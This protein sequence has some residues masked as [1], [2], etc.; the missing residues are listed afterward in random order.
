MRQGDEGQR[1]IGVAFDVGPLA[2][3]RTGIGAAV[4]ALRDHL[5]HE[6]S[7]RLLP[8]L[9]S[10]RATPD[11]GVRR[12]P[13]PAMVAHR[14]WARTDRPRADRWLGRADVVHGTNYV[15][16]PSAAP[17]IVSVYDCWFLAHGREAHPDVVRA[18]RVLLRSLEHGAV[19]HASSH[20][21][22]AALL[23]HSPRADVRVVHLGAMPLP[24]PTA[25]CP[26]AELDGRPYV[27]AVATL[28]RRKNLPRLV[29]AFGEVASAVPDVRLVIAGGDGD[30]RRDVDAAIDRLPPSVGGRVLL[31]GYVDDAV[32]AWLLHHARVLAY[33]SLDEGFGFPLLDAMQADLP[34]VASDA[35]SIPEVAGPAALMSPARDV[36]ALGANLVRALTDEALRSSLVAAGRAQLDRFTWATS[37]AGMADLYRSLVDHHPKDS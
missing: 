16:P 28:E 23:E 35:G 34:I 26:I 14:V 8:Y 19:A 13:M 5:E 37:M 31:T 32:R 7:I 24:T 1:T 33:P 29:E 30:D 21:T 2:G 15:V 4:G 3:R 20:A 10:F 9:T 18:G 36:D 11:V 6:P 17:R 22:K 25:V 12:L 27:L